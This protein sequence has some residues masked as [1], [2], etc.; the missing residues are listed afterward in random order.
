[1]LEVL[2]ETRFTNAMQVVEMLKRQVEEHRAG[3]DPND[4]LTMICLK[5]G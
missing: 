2:R 3:A 4:D 1:M 5:V